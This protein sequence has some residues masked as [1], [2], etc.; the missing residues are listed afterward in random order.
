MC[1][2]RLINETKMSHALNKIFIDVIKVVYSSI[3][4]MLKP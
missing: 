1:N 3:L 4:S 2:K